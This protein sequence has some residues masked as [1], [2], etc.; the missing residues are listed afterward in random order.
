MVRR[1]GKADEI[2]ALTVP[3]SR[4][5]SG[6]LE[7]VARVSL[8]LATEE[9]VSTEFGSEPV[10]LREDVSRFLTLVGNDDCVGWPP[11]FV[12]VVPLLIANEADAVRA[13]VVDTVGSLE[14][15]VLSRTVDS[16]SWS[17]VSN[18]VVWLVVRV[19]MSSCLLADRVEVD[20]RVVENV[21]S[22]L[23]VT[24]LVASSSVVTDSVCA[25]SDRLES[26]LRLGLVVADTRQPPVVAVFDSTVDRDDARRSV[27]PTLSV[28]RGVIVG[29]VDEAASG[30]FVVVRR[31]NES[32]GTLYSSVSV[33]SVDSDRFDDTDAGFG[34]TVVEA[35]VS[36]VSM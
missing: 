14:T 23:P 26:E 16:T 27:K 6:E 24:G 2:L 29:V 19:P 22:L 12:G 8:L 30:E 31:V 4:D 7:S 20:E 3:V 10:V 18:D 11:S 36:S 17:L 1:V 21:R 28:L 13:E 15:L 32:E 5:T 25:A 35:L 34:L 33:D 9:V